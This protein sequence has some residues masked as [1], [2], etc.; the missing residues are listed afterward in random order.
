MQYKKL[1]EGSTGLHFITGANYSTLPHG[2]HFITGANYSTLPHGTLPQIMADKR[3]TRWTT[4][5]VNTGAS[6]KEGEL[7][8]LF[9]EVQ[10]EAGGVRYQFTGIY[11]TIA[12]VDKA[13]SSGPVK[14]ITWR[15]GIS[16]HHSD[17]EGKFMKDE[18]AF[19]LYL[20]NIN[21][22]SLWNAN[23]AVSG[24]GVV[25]LPSEQQPRRDSP[26]SFSALCSPVIFTDT[27]PLAPSAA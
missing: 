9:I 13:G 11:G 26:G 27:M 10:L 4:T 21:V 7:V 5:L 18:D 24:H 14:S 12:R 3:E 8:G 1:L 17:E 15:T 16:V 22:R 20:P 25:S 23:P 6:Y 19:L 2:L